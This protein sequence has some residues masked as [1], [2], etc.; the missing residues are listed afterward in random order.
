MTMVPSALSP[1]L[2]AS[3]QPE[4][5]AYELKFTLD[6]EKAGLVEH[7]A[8]RHMAPDPHGDP[9]LGGA[10]R[11][12]SLYLDT[13]ALDVYRARPAVGARRGHASL[14]TWSPLRRFN[15]RRGS[16]APSRAGQACRDRLPWEV[17]STR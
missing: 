17:G 13:P 9:A 1:S 10:Y 2:I 15:P 5:P 6:A 11:I 8:R 3:L 14:K 16:R 12:H 4:V 7:W